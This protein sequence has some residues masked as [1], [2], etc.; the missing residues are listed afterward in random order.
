MH[1][2]L[3][4]AKNA[5]D[6]RMDK[7]HFE[8]DEEGRIVINMT[9]N[10]DDDFLS[11][12][13]ISHT[14]V[15]SEDVAEFIENSTEYLPAKEPLTLRI[16]SHCIDDEE[17]EIYRK[18]IHEYYMQK[19]I[20]NENEIKKDKW[21]SIALLFFGVMTLA[22]E[23]FYSYHAGNEI[24]TQVIDIVAWVLLWEACDIF[25][26]EGRKLRLKRKHYLGYLSMKIEYIG[27]YRE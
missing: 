17:K 24:W 23:I 1:S 18:A 13:S 6:Q 4:K 11:R 7:I 10:N 14:P 5:A 26:F 8:K 15:I 12:F 19:Y 21:I 9:V 25:V 22:F 2:I 16:H 27:E 3:E 20:V